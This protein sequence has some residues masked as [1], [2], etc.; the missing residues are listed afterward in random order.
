MKKRTLLSFLFVV[1]MFSVGSITGQVDVKERDG[2]FL[3]FTQVKSV[4]TKVMDKERYK[5]NIYLYD[6]WRFATFHHSEHSAV[7]VD[8]VKL[9]IF[10]GEVEVFQNDQYLTLDNREFDSFDFGYDDGDFK[11]LYK[12]KHYYFDNDVRLPGIIKVIELGEHSVIVAYVSSVRNDSEKNPL[13]MESLKKDKIVM[14]KHR[15]IEKDGVLFRIKNKKDFKKFFS[16]RPDIQKFISSQKLNHKHE[17]DIAK[18]VVEA[19]G[20]G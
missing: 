20:A 14:H 4:T 5:G 9:N 16:D 6:N 11:A 17:G 3:V 7:S 10:R 12:T 1:V 8:S 13:M 18:A 19:Y 15:Y 2:D